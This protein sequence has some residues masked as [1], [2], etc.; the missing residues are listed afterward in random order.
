MIVMG[1]VCDQNN[2]LVLK[3]IMNLWINWRKL[4]DFKNYGPRFYFTYLLVTGRFKTNF[5]PE[6]FLCYFKI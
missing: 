4:P 6:L 1:K 2:F 5:K 3:I